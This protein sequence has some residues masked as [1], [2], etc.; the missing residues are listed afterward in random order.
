[1]SIGLGLAILRTQVMARLQFRA[2]AFAQL[3][4]V[5]FS[6]LIHNTIIV[7][8]YTYGN[9]HNA[10]MTLQQAVSYMWIVHI[11]LHLLPGMGI[12]HEIKEKI[13][14]GDVSTELC[15]PLDLYTHWYLRA[16]AMRLGPCLVYLLPVA[17]CA[18]IVPEP[19]R[20]RPPASWLALLACIA[21]LL[22]GLLL[23]C[24]TMGLT[25]VLLMRVS[26]GDGPI[27]VMAAVTDLLSGANLPLQLW[28]AKLQRVLM[29]QPFAGIIDIPLRLYVG[30]M[31]PSAFLSSALLQTAWLLCFLLAGWYLMRQVLE[32][33]VIQ[34]G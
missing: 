24:A 10:S 32:K 22:L 31:S 23:T 28:P 6:A 14:S 11:V 19:Y 20:L 1:M 18:L 13:R 5:V 12:D 26:W 29:Y 27:Y 21:S 34:G 30:T 15:R 9:G 2:A 16:A 25:N 33:T 3:S 17:L 8:F 4:T 7:A